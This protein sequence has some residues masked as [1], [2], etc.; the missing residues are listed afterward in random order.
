MR[1]AVKVMLFVVAG[2]TL[3]AGAAVGTAWYQGRQ[4]PV[5]RPDYVA[6]GS[7][8]AAGA[9]LGLLQSGSPLLCARSVAGYPQQLATTLGVKI[10][11]MSCGG[12]TTV[13]VLHGGQFFQG[14]QIRTIKSQTRLVTITS[15]GNDVNFIGDLSMLALRRSDGILGALGRTFWSG[16]KTMGDRG[17]VELEHTLL[18][19]IAAIRARAP[20]A[21]IV[22]ATYPTI[23]PPTGT[24]AALRLSVAE[25]DRMRVVERQ[26]AATT[27]AA[28]KQG[29]AMLVD[30]NALGAAHNACAAVPWTR[31]MAALSD[32]PFHPTIAGAHATAAA[33]TAALAHQQL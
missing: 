4:T 21:K 31:G 16:P 12:A 28:A 5:G 3:L 13:N 18:D 14:P 8:F 7:S 9:G 2:L 24:C 23:L 29:D 1:R 11:D 25:A 26:L 20:S 22:V 32:A 10:V 33:I 6:L 30:M 17:F 15:G 19:L 27:R